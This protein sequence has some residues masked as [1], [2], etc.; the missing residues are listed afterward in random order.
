MLPDDP[1]AVIDRLAA[2]FERLG[3]RY[4]VGGSVASSTHGFA[5]ST[6]DVDMVADVTE[7]Q[8]PALVAALEAD[9]Y[10]DG[11][12]MRAALEQGSSFNLIH[13]PTMVKADVFVFTG[14]P[15]AISGMERRIAGL[16]RPNAP[17]VYVAS[18]EDTVLQKLLWYRLTGERSDRQWG[19]VQGVLK[20]QAHDLDGAYL[21]HWARELD[22]ADLLEQALD[23]AGLHFSIS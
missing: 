7:A 19:D 11:D 5:R 2:V 12:L 21:H 23:D 13:L 10:A 6:N 20:V 17:P 14:S 22:I 8:I 4:L 18:P 3:I 15:F 1:L 9:F 16:L